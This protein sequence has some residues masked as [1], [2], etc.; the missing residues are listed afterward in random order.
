MRKPKKL[1]LCIIGMPGAGKSTVAEM[2][3]KNFRTCVFETGDAIREEIRKRGLRYT[4]END[5]KIAEWFHAGRERLIMERTAERMKSCSRRILIVTGFFSPDEYKILKT[6]GRTV[7]IAVT[8]PSAVRHK[9][10]LLRR[11]FGNESEKYLRD[12]DRRELDEGLGK[13]LKKAD[14]RISSN[15]GKRELEKKVVRLVRKIIQKYHYD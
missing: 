14:Y 12:R 15:Y 7:L 11:R 9:R 4:K 13:L 8:A 10:E 3:G 2:I 5:A 1:I 6:L